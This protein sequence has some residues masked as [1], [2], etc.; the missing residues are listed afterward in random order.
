MVRARAF[1]FHGWGFDRRCWRPW[2]DWLASRGVTLEA[3]DRGY[4]GDTRPAPHEPDV[5]SL[6]LAHSFGL[7][8]IPAGQ[9]ARAEGLVLFAGFI[10]YHPAEE[11]RRGGSI[12][13]LTSLQEELA[14]DPREAL[15]RFRRQC[16]RPRDP[17]PLPGEEPRAERLA[18]DLEALEGS[19]ADIGA[20][21]RVP[22]VLWFHGGLDR[23]VPLDVGR[24]LANALPRAERLERPRAGH[25]LPFSDAAWCQEQAGLW[26]DRCCL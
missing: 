18:E 8:R 11:P 9:L 1:A 2:A 25:A 21:R 5:P 6:L 3:D 15:A 22:H 12:A 26:M 24:A 19:R 7:H 23:I 17:D 13:A 14:R 16:F 4:F 10:T 20:L